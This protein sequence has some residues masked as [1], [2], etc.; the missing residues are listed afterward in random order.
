MTELP[1]RL[2]IR[3]LYDRFDTPVTEFDCG[4]RCSPH[5]PSG[6]PFCCDICHAVPVAYRQ[7]WDYLQR[8]T[9]LW[10]VWQ[11]DEC[12]T[13]PSDPAELR[14]QTPEHLLLLACQ[15]PAHCQRQYRASSCRQFPF[16]PYV[17][18]DY[19]FLGLAYEW[20]FEPMCWVIS[21]L[22]A[23]T[24]AYWSEFVRVYDELFARWQ[25]EFDSYAACSEDMRR[26]FAA[27]KRRIPLLHRNGGYYLISPASER[28]QRVTPERFRR[29]GPYQSES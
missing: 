26:H 8:N 17:T 19:R 15:G 27:Q 12:P 5:N 20:D 13:D 29:F 18:S 11:G 21:H 3:R 7:E 22:E 10:H 6:K 1:P 14:S 2:D 4:T 16:F 9:D 28:M 24:T 23:V 25:T